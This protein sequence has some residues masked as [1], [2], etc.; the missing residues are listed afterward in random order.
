MGMI[1]YRN[2]LQILECSDRIVRSV[3]VPR[4]EEEYRLQ[5]AALRIYTEA[6]NELTAE[7]FPTEQWRGMRCIQTD[8]ETYMIRTA[9]PDPDTDGRYVP[10]LFERPDFVFRRDER[11]QGIADSGVAGYRRIHVEAAAPDAVIPPAPEHVPEETATADTEIPEN[12]E[13]GL[14][15]YDYDALM[16]GQADDG[17]AEDRTGTAEESPETG[18]AAEEP[19]RPGSVTAAEDSRTFDY[20]ALLRE[21]ERMTEA[22]KDMFGTDE[23]RTQPGPET[24]DTA[25]VLSAGSEEA[26]ETGYA[27]EAEETGYAGETEYRDSYETEEPR[28]ELPEDTAGT[29]DDYTEPEQDP[30][31]LNGAD[32]TEEPEETEETENTD[33]GISGMQDRDFTM[34][35]IRAKVMKNG[36][37]LAKCEFIIAPMALEEDS[38]DIIVWCMSGQKAQV[39]TSAKKKPSVLIDVR[40]FGVIV[41]GVCRNGNFEAGIRLRKMDTDNGITLIQEEP[42]TFG[43]KGHIVI[44]DE[45]IAIHVIPTSFRNNRT[46]N[47]DYFYCI[48]TDTERIGANARG[49]EAVDFGY[50]G[51]QYKLI[52]RWKEDTNTLYAMVQEA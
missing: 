31:S 26:E 19:F 38:R 1:Y 37:E 22:A 8:G 32:G 48:E 21:T 50:N 51:I 35:Y 41:S 40:D 17:P 45:G 7:G 16:E 23:D 2:L 36:A 43:G 25:P 34:T 44:R 39:L 42:A 6:V 47:A 5:S 28:T 11:E 46:G 3:N 49:V 9:M 10:G 4:S 20:E 52:C 14:E 29:P 27:G 13:D 30:D 15:E 18:G 33:N 24:P 12:D